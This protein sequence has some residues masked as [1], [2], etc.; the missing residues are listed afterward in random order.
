M[1]STILFFLTAE[2]PYGAGETFIE[3]EISYLAESFD[4]VVLLPLNKVGEEHRKIPCN[5]IIKPI[6]KRQISW[7]KVF[8]KIF[9]EAEIFKEFIFNTTSNPLKNKILLKSIRTAINIA[10]NLEMRHREYKSGNSFFYSYWL[11]DTALGVSFLNH[12]IKF[13]RAHGWDVYF[14]RHP[15]GYLPLRQFLLKKIDRIFCISENGK[16]YFE[17]KFD[18][19][20]KVEVSRLGTINRY[21][22]NNK[23]KDSGL[24]IISIGNVIPLKRI[25]LIGEAIQIINS[26][27]ISWYHFGDGSLFEQTK[28][29]FPFAIFRGRVNNYELKKILKQYSLSSVL[30]N[31]SST[32]GIPVSMMEAMSFGIPCIGTNVGGVS[33]IIEDNVNG[34]LIPAD[35]TPEIVSEY[36]KK[37]INLTLEEKEEFRLNAFNTW[38][39]KY[40]A[41]KNYKDFINCIYLLK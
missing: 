12:S 2:F 40:D 24:N 14:E 16:F 9:N 13:S 17:S 34:F 15:F 30:I 26:N 4:K 23:I 18:G 27:K 35:P 25:N 8:S 19:H 41:E 37:Y 6:Q 1:K 7:K 32:E 33:E 38:K 10:E 20:S 11:D 22:F 39:E 36:I 29:S 21:P 28:N 31:T 5:V 3:N